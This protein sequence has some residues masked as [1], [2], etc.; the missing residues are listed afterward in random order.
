MGISISIWSQVE[1]LA[2]DIDPEERERLQQEVEAEIAE[3]FVFAEESRCPDAQ[4]LYADVFKEQ[5][6]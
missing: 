3:A 5:E 2:R 1:R 6:A 4:E